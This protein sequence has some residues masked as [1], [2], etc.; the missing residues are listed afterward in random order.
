MPTSPGMAT[1][2]QPARRRAGA[3]PSAEP[4]QRRSP[5]TPPLPS[6][7]SSRKAAG[8]DGGGRAMQAKF[9]GGGGSGDGLGNAPLKRAAS[10][11]PAVLRVGL[12]LPPLPT[13]GSAEKTPPPLQPAADRSPVAESPASPT[14]ATAPPGPHSAPFSR[15]QTLAKPPPRNAVTPS[16]ALV[17]GMSRMALSGQLVPSPPTMDGDDEVP[18]VKKL[19]KHMSL[20]PRRQEP[21]Q[22]AAAAEAAAR[23]F[24]AW[25]ED[26]LQFSKRLEAPLMA[27]QG[28]FAG[29]K[30]LRALGRMGQRRSTCTFS[31]HVHG[32]EGLPAELNGRRLLIEWRRR[33][34]AARTAP[35]TIINGVAEVEQTLHLKCTLYVGA[36]PNETSKY[37]PKSSTLTVAALEN[38][39]SIGSGRETV[40]GR[41]K[42]DLSRVLPSKL[43]GAAGD[44]SP[45][46]TSFPLDRVA[47]REA[48]DLLVTFG[49]EVQMPRGGGTRAAR[50][51]SR[52]FNRT[53]SRPETPGRDSPGPTGLAAAGGAVATAADDAGLAAGATNSAETANDDNKEVDGNVTSV[54]ADVN[55]GTVEDVPLMEVVLEEV[56][57]VEEEEKEEEGQEKEEEE[58]KEEEEESAATMAAEDGGDGGEVQVAEETPVAG[59]QG[60]AGK[61]VDEDDE[62]EDAQDGEDDDEE[63][64]DE[65][66]ERDEDEVES[67]DDEDAEA[68]RDRATA[69]AGETAAVDG[70][71]NNS[72]SPLLPTQA[73]S[74]KGGLKS[75]WGSPEVGG[76]ETLALP[77]KGKESKLVK[78][79]SKRASVASADDVT[80]VN[81][82]D[83]GVGGGEVA[84]G[85]VRKSRRSKKGTGKGTSKAAAAAAA[86]IAS[87]VDEASLNGGHPNEGGDVSGV[88]AEHIDNVEQPLSEGAVQS[89]HSTALSAAVDEPFQVKGTTEAAPASESAVVGEEPRDAVA[90]IGEAGLEEAGSGQVQQAAL[91]S[92]VAMAMAGL[93]AVGGAVAAAVGSMA[94]GGAAA[95]GAA[96]ASA[97]GAAGAA[98]AVA[99][100]AALAPMAVG[101]LA[102]AGVG[103]G[104]MA[105]G[106][107]L[108]T[109]RNAAAAQPV[110]EEGASASE[111][112]SAAVLS[113]VTSEHGGEL[114]VSKASGE[115]DGPLPAA[116]AAD[117]D[118]DEFLG[119]LEEASRGPHSG[120][121]A[122]TSSARD[123]F[124]YEGQDGD[125]GQW[126][127]H[128]ARGVLLSRFEEAA[129]GAGEDRGDG[130]GVYEG[131]WEDEDTEL[132]RMLEMAEEEHRR[133]GIL[134]RSRSRAKALED[135]ETEALMLAMGMGS[136]EGLGEEGRR[137]VL[138]GKLA[139]DTTLARLEALQP[140]ALADGVGSAVQIRD[141]GVLRSMAPRHFDPTTGRLVMQVSKPVVVPKEL[142][143][144]AMEIIHRMAGAG[145]ETMTLQA[146][147]A[148]PLEDIGGKSV[149]QIQAEGLALEGSPSPLALP[150]SHAR[151]ALE[152][153]G[154]GSH[155][156]LEGSS[157]SPGGSGDGSGALVLRQ[158]YGPLVPLAGGAATGRGAA[159]APMAA[160]SREALHEKARQIVLRQQG[161]ALVPQGSRAAATSPRGQPEAGPLARRSSGGSLATVGPSTPSGSHGTSALQTAS[162]AGPPAT[163]GELPDEFV[164]LQE[165]APLAMQTIEY[166]AMEG[167]KIQAGYAEEDAPCTVEALSWGDTKALEGPYG[168]KRGTKVEM[169]GGAAT[170]HLLEGRKASAAD[171]PREDEERQHK[172]DEVDAAAAAAAD[173]K[174]LMSMA[175]SL[176]EWTRLDA[177][178]FDDESTA[179]DTLA[180][181]AAHQAVHKDLIMVDDGH[182]KKAL[183]VVG[184]APRGAAA[185]GKKKSRGG[186]GGDNSGGVMGNTITLAMLVQL[187]DPAR[188]Y[189][190]VGA[191]MMA[192]VQAERM[193]VPKPAKLARRIS[194]KGDAGRGQDSTSTAAAAAGAAAEED[195][196]KSEARFK[197]TGI[198]MTGLQADSGGKRRMWGTD[199]AHQAGSRWLAANG[200]GKGRA[201]PLLK[202]KPPP[203]R[204]R[205]K[206]GETLW[207]ISQRVH[208]TG[209]RWT[210]V[211]A[212]N[213]HIRNPDV[214]FA[215]ESIRM[216]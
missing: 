138:G 23:D 89:D 130:G 4:P 14:P 143:S 37:T 42:L 196:Q 202:T 94:A 70:N 27:K 213:P 176:D 91:R 87:A 187:R 120:A 55:G 124:S 193:V 38:G 142:G 131:G 199:K 32:V 113:S 210:E 158:N 163:H 108:Y 81:G 161:G 160:S 74:P 21:L 155:L 45:W 166:L 106:S 73:Q 13:A 125:S 171:R 6:A 172:R 11:S 206:Q 126:E 174:D 52:V 177:G 209:T 96:A 83:V 3:S 164:S 8:L 159:A 119:M 7:T 39:T 135:E 192:L 67:M 117:M 18:V 121:P 47:N 79:K 1:P 175:I 116:A 149:Q 170:V 95:G 101:G 92:R 97:A 49:Y 156:R 12:G 165:L 28:F 208:G 180:V 5:A 36:G 103:V 110:V 41:H 115:V 61:D 16:A 26:Q 216:R 25:L 56:S 77:T 40:L 198:H 60:Q 140:P 195:E 185:I 80:P 2:P 54:D 137:A 15:V 178:V 118:E 181:L 212:L 186:S 146:M 179:D 44:A 29:W 182:G 88:A 123:S 71:A 51:S 76:G 57:K 33:E 203:S 59:L 134:E 215:D 147:A 65:D 184:Q 167:L 100:A 150:A 145:A 111:E 152:A 132:A 127:G 107:K 169:L 154:A 148:M 72:S 82:A 139:V 162:G 90:D 129:A 68:D 205:V 86:G 46:T 200:M 151:L 31:L 50:V 19:T 43:N 17:G 204:V 24:A 188:N 136:I 30:P 69:V 141:G 62:D 207:S 214:I 191:P 84:S 157:C 112:S 9:A 75:S 48:S 78:K 34:V 63:G 64:E 189:E 20:A 144:S 10:A 128:A 104:A 98:A 109:M 53:A 85:I 93:T 35:A 114:S 173:D 201:H 58:D 197:I 153:N 66:E 183:Q 105:V 122:D 22:G 99:G 194:Y 168:R 190:P 102:V 133:A 211:A